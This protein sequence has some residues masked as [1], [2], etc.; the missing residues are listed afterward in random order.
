MPAQKE[1]LPEQ[2]RIPILGID[3]LVQHV[4]LT[5]SG[6]MAV[7]TN[8]TDVGWYRY[9]TA[10]GFVGSAVIDGH[11]DN[12]LRLPGVFKKLNGLAVGDEIFVRTAAG[13]ELR[14]VVQ[15]V[16]VYGYKEVPTEVLFNRADTARLNLVTCDGAWVAGEK[17]YDKRLVVY[18]VLAP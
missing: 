13:A 10:P 2:L 4:G 5:K 11:V 18:A 6:K 17:T 9:G 16:A 15:E 8:F 7:P 12:G 1:E 3:A 14:F